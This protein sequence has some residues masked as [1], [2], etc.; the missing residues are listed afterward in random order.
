M[1]KKGPL[2]ESCV[3][4]NRD[5]FRLNPMQGTGRVRKSI[6]RSCVT[7]LGAMREGRSA[8]IFD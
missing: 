5:T 7:Y 1:E 4:L 6:S 2:F 3:G 8:P